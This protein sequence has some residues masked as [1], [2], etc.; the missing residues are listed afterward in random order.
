[1]LTY[2]GWSLCE[3]CIVCKKM[4]CA[5]AQVSKA[6]PVVTDLI[7][8]HMRCELWTSHCELAADDDCGVTTPYHCTL[9]ILLDKCMIK[10]EED[11]GTS[12]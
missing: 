11:D 7:L 2:G 6:C 1:M 10:G 9:N 5:V 3:T 12:N 4:G 8:K